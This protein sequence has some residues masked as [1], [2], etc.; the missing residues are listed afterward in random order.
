MM[1][2]FWMFKNVA[3]LMSSFVC[4]FEFWCFVLV[5]CKGASQYVQCMA[6]QYGFRRYELDFL[7][8]LVWYGDIGFESFLV[9]G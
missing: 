3:E 8:D 6:A 4:F 2:M 9:C 5:S 1:R 7:Y